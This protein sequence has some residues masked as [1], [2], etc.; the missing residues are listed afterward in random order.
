MNEYEQCSIYGFLWSVFLFCFMGVCFVFVFVF[1]AYVVVCLSLPVL[2]SFG[3][4]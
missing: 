2:L 1:V 3:E 4:Q